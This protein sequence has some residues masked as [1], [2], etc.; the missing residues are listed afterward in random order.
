MLCDMNGGMLVE[1]FK[2][3][4][5]CVIKEFGVDKVGVYCYND[6]GFGV[7]FLFVGI[8]VGVLFV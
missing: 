5:V 1:D 7:V 3:I 8:S 2:D 6:S 4:V